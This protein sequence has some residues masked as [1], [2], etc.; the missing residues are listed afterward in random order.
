[1]QLIIHLSGDGAKTEACVNNYIQ[2][3]DVDVIT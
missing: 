3:F 2:W 1:M